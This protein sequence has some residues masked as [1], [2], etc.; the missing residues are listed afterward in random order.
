MTLIVFQVIT[1]T[2]SSILH[3]FGLCFGVQD[4]GRPEPAPMAMARR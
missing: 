3:W 4:L 1:Q 2:I